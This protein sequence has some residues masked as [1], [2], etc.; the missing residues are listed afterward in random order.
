MGWAWIGEL[1][2]T[3]GALGKLRVHSLV[4][5]RVHED[6]DFLIKFW[7][8]GVVSCCLFR[9]LHLGFFILDLCMYVYI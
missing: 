4:G 3:F 1:F 2:V 5:T 6:V 9:G 7:V 8:I